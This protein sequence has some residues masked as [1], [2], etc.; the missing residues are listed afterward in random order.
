MSAGKRGTHS[1]PKSEHTRDVSYLES[2]FPRVFPHAATQIGPSSQTVAPPSRPSTGVLPRGVA[3]PFAEPPGPPPDRGSHLPGRPPRHPSRIEPR[4]PEHP[5]GFAPGLTPGLVPVPRPIDLPI[6]QPRPSR[7]LLP[8]FPPPRLLGQPV[9]LPRHL[10]DKGAGRFD[11][12]R[13]LPHDTGAGTSYSTGADRQERDEV[14]SRTYV[15]ASGGLSLAEAIIRA[16]RRIDGLHVQYLDLA[17]SPNPKPF[18]TVG[19]RKKILDQLWQEM[20]AEE[21]RIVHWERQLGVFHS[22]RI[23]DLPQFE[24][25]GPIQ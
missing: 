18:E 4:R 9:I 5:R 20:R 19:S 23:T 2:R 6:P 13:G 15:P 17:V 16:R 21:D 10:A 3:R 8:S 24:R 22:P 7:S 1:R 14:A 11:S 25:E 12:S